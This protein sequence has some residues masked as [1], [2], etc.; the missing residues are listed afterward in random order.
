MF[1]E[2]RCP[3][4]RRANKTRMGTDLK[5]TGK[6]TPSSAPETVSKIWSF[7]WWLFNCNLLN[8]LSLLNLFCTVNTC[9]RRWLSYSLKLWLFCSAKMRQGTGAMQI[10]FIVENWWWYSQFTCWRAGGWS[11]MNP[12]QAGALGCFRNPLPLGNT[13]SR[14]SGSACSRYR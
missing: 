9:R 10:R 1:E 12:S 13:F 3:S 5:R 6:G 2:G 14:L 8:V 4:G 7:P 11:F